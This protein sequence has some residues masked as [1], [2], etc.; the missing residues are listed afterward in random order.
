[1]NASLAP[2]S[3]S[4]PSPSTTTSYIA[5]VIGTIDCVDPAGTEADESYVRPG[6]FSGL[7]KLSLDP[8]RIAPRAK[9]FRI[10]SKPTVLIIRDDLR[11]ILDENG[12]SGVKYINMGEECMIY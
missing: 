2:R 11:S 3:N 8:A 4:F 9:L 12:T 10:K 5:N 1:L 6:Q 7:F